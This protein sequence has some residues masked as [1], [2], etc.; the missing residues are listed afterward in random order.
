MA[1]AMALLSRDEA[2]RRKLVRQGLDRVKLFDTEQAARAL[3]ALLTESG[4]GTG[5][6]LDKTGYS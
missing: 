2:L 1:D 4:C 6:K 3:W 5:A